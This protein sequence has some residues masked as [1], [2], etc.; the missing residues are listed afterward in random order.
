LST[1]WISF[2]NPRLLEG[3]ALGSC[4]LMLR[5]TWLHVRIISWALGTWRSPARDAWHPRAAAFL[6]A[7]NAANVSCTSVAALARHIRRVDVLIWALIWI[8]V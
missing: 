2:A 1:A 6:A 3:L 4:R 5:P 7:R 8:N